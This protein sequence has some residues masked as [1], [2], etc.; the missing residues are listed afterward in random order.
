MQAQNLLNCLL[1]FFD[2]DKGAA[3]PS[4]DVEIWEALTECWHVSHEEIG[5]PSLNDVLT[6]LQYL[7]TF[8]VIDVSMVDGRWSW[9]D[10]CPERWM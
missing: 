6:T 2:P 9:K 5:V 4:T 3:E 8:N 7:R 10:N 1:T